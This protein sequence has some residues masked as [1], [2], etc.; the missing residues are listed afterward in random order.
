MATRYVTK[1]TLDFLQ[2]LD[3]H[4]ERTWFKAHQA[5]Y[6]KLVREPLLHFIEDVEPSIHRRISKHIVCDARKVGGSLF[7]IQRDTRFA[8]DKSP[9]KT[10]SG[11]AF[12]HEVGKEAAAPTLY[13]NIEPGNCFFGVGIYRPPSD[14]LR[15]LRDAMVEDPR[16]WTKARDAV[17]GKRWAQHG[18]QLTRAPRGFDAD[19]PLVDDLRRTSHAF[20]RAVSEREV[21]STRLVDLFVD[22]CAETLPAL[23][24]QAKAVGV[25]F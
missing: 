4:N 22:R 13:F 21:T 16:G 25:P 9:Y 14:A 7:R 11:V 6:E 15:R 8:H 12:R 5:D 20:T 17:L 2:D 10:N 1:A 19:H 23:R 18:D 24:W 3:L